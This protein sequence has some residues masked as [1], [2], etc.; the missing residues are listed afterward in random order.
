MHP[1]PGCPLDP[2]RL[3]KRSS[4]QT[5]IRRTPPPGT[6]PRPSIQTPA[7]RHDMVD[8]K[9]LRGTE[10]L[11]RKGADRMDEQPEE[12]S[13]EQRE[14]QIEE[15][16][17]YFRQAIA[18][19]ESVPPWSEW[20]QENEPLVERVFP[21]ME[22]VRLK[23]RTPRR[24]ADP[25]AVRRAAEGLHPTQPAPH[26]LLRTLRGAS[27]DLHHRN[28]ERAH[29]LSALRDRLRRLRRTGRFLSRIKSSRDGARIG[30]AAESTRLTARRT[31]G[32]AAIRRNSGPLWQLS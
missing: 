2:V 26:G 25:P 15:C 29:H 23:H 13:E 16:L 17:V 19:P 24:A 9:P 22:Y 12:Q 5:T 30:R 27:P 3:C 11:A 21:L 20:W 1:P 31:A 32:D 6:V 10:R 4:R 14:Q 7:P 18:S 28:G 8:G